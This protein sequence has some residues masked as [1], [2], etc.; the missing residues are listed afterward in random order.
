LPRGYDGYGGNYGGYGGGYGR[1][2]GGLGMTTVATA[3]VAVGEGTEF[4]ASTLIL[5]PGQKV[6][7]DT[8]AELRYEKPGT[9][10]NI[11]MKLL[12]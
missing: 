7:R 9:Y 8:K 11:K 2:G 10:A 1:Y 5:A 3:A 12:F 4:Y 6:P